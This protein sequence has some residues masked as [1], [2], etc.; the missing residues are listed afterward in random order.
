MLNV[1]RT[2]SSLALAALLGAAS[3]AHA[4][5]APAVDAT[6]QKLIDQI[7]A[8]WH[9]ENTVLMAVQRPAAAVMEQSRAAL[10]QRQVPQAQGEAVL[11]DISTDVQKY[12]ETADALATQSAKKAFPGTVAPLLAQTFSVDELKQLLAMLQSPVKAKFEKLV[13]QVDQALGKKVQDDIGAEI[14]KDIQAMNAAATPKLRA[15]LAAS[16]PK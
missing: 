1:K 13:P 5:S 6:K 7:L 12:V 15:A 4:Q 14:N 8:L 11:K 16:A 3:L 2:L 9:P 10:Q